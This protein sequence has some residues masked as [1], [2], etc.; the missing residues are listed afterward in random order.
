MNHVY[1]IPNGDIELG[2]FPYRRDDGW[3]NVVW[4]INEHCN[5]RCPYCVTGWIRAAGSNETIVD[6]VGIHGT[7][8]RF[9]RISDMNG[10]RLYLTITGGEPTLVKNF[11][12]LC[13]A[14]GKAGFHIELQTNL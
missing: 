8:D 9:G 11:V 10:K 4:I 14:L 13:E 12:P 2:D 6:R 3:T 1:P 7:V 5:L